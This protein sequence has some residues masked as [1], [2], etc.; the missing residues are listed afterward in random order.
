MDVTVTLSKGN[1]TIIKLWTHIA[2]MNSM[3]AFERA[4]NMEQFFTA[5]TDEKCISS[6]ELCSFILGNGMKSW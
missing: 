4:V 3:E 6:A 2:Y 5:R 1:A